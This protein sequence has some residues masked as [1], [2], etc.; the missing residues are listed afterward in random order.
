MAHLKRWLVTREAQMDQNKIDHVTW[1]EMNAAAQRSHARARLLGCRRLGVEIIDRRVRGG[2]TP[3][4]HDSPEQ[5]AQEKRR[6]T[7]GTSSR[8]NLQMMA[9]SG[10]GS[11]RTSSQ[12][13]AASEPRRV[14][15]AQQIPAK[16]N[17]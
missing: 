15:E 14:D 2:E 16:A 8:G 5:R 17:V 7:P 11:Q 6:G 12:W 9:L 4:V 10:S 13:P 1:A 3:L